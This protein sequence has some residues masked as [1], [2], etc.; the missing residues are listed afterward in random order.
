[1]CSDDLLAITTVFVAKNN[2][3][4]SAKYRKE[5]K[6]NNNYSKVN[7]NKEELDFKSELKQQWSDLYDKNY[8]CIKSCVFILLHIPF[9]AHNRL[10][11]YYILYL[12]ATCSMMI[13]KPGFSLMNSA[14][15]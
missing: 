11:L 4:R 6:E 15:K 14:N 2:G 5:R 10:L 8:R 12:L 3:I 7:Y 1:M 9:I 13:C